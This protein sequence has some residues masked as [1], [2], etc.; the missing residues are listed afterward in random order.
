MRRTRRIVAIGA[1][2]SALIVGMV[3]PTLVASADP[4]VEVLLSGLSSPKGLALDLDDNLIVGQG[5]FGP[6]GPVLLFFLRGPDQGTA[7]EVTD[8]VNVMDVA[9]GPDGSGWAIGGDGVLYRQ[10]IGGDIE[11]V[12]DIL[13]YQ[14]GDPDPF[15]Q[16]GNP[17]ESN[18]YGLAVLPTGDALVADAAGNDLLRVT[19]AG[20]ATTMARFD[21]ETVSTI[22][23]EAVPTTVTIGPDGAVYVG[24]LQGA[25]FLPGT[26]HIWRIDPNASGVLCSVDGSDPGCSM[27]AEGFTAVVDIAFDARRGKLYVYELAE[28]GVLAFEAGFETGEFPPAVLLSVRGDKRRE[29]AAGLL[30]QPGGVVVTHRGDV[31]VTD[32]MFSDGRLVHVRR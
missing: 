12:L 11:A 23:S 2:C 19:P 6:P 5:A 29:I 28:D 24:E 18:P 31:F 3:G 21:V 10:E 32:G 15:D 16:E 27:Y 25:P 30:S 22:E 13:A 9:I 26:S 1:V 17:T 20:V 7:V 14:A 4:Q 8:P